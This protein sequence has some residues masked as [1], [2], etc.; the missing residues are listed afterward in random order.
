MINLLLGIREKYGIKKWVFFVSH[1]CDSVLTQKEVPP[2]E[3]EKPLPV[4][5]WII[6][7]ALGQRLPCPDPDWFFR[8]KAFTA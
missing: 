4:A 1:S 3:S 6:L 5:V 7:E 2:T 8:A